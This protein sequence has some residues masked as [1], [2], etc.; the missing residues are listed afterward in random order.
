MLPPECD[1]G[2]FSSLLALAA[3]ATCHHLSPLVR[4]SPPS[5]STSLMLS[6]CRVSP[7]PAKNAGTARLSLTVCRSGQKLRKSGELHSS[8]GW[9]LEIWTTMLMECDIFWVY[10][11]KNRWWINK[12]LATAILPP[13]PITNTQKRAEATRELI[14]KG[15]SRFPRM[16]LEKRHELTNLASDVG[17]ELSLAWLCSAAVQFLSFATSSQPK[18]SFCIFSANHFGRKRLFL[19]K[20]P[21]SAKISYFCSLL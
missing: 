15:A 3:T 17:Q 21:I 18:R 7:P 8:K 14:K 11:T 12:V 13:N 6:P 20:G 5:L 1:F 2:L 16:Y 9:N 10:K 19:Q 4:S